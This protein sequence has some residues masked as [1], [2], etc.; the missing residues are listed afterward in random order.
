MGWSTWLESWCG[1]NQSLVHDLFCELPLPYP[2]STS[3]AVTVWVLGISIAL[4]LAI[5]HCGDGILR[6]RVVPGSF[7]KGFRRCHSSRVNDAGV[8]PFVQLDTQQLTLQSLQ[9][10]WF[11]T[12]TVACGG[13]YSWFPN[14]LPCQ[15]E[16][17][18]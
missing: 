3:R 15:P 13:L 12:A 18:W 8:H 10:P 17:M 16:Q 5:I 7:S 14:A 6:V 4:A 1:G 11:L 9:H 2:L